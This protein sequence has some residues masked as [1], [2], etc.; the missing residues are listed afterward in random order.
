MA[1][2]K[3]LLRVIAEFSGSELMSGGADLRNNAT[4]IGNL[5]Q[6]HVL[7]RYGSEVDAD[8]PVVQAV[9]YLLNYAFEI[10]HRIFT[11]SPR[12]ESWVR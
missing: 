3:S 7:E 5:E 12:D 4:D 10:A 1:S 6:L 8:K 9:W 11:S 2:K